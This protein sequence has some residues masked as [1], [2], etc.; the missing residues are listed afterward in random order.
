LKKITDVRQLINSSGK[1][2]LLE[3]DG[4]VTVDNAGSIFG[5]GADI[6]VGGA[7]VFKSADYVSTIHALKNSGSS[8]K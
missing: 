6:L 8:K 4:G 7:S 1:K 5:A 2:I 3:V